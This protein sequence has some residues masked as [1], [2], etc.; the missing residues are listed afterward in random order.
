MI[1]ERDGRLVLTDLLFVSGV[2]IYFG[3]VGSVVQRPWAGAICGVVLALLYSAYA[4]V[5]PRRHGIM[6]GLVTGCVM[7]T[8]VGLL[9]LWVDGVVNSVVSGALFGVLRGGAIGALVGAITRVQPD[10]DDPWHISAFLAVGSV[11][12]GMLLGVGVG[13]MAGMILGG[14]LQRDVWRFLISLPLGM[15]V[16]GYLASYYKRRWYRLLG[17]II[18]FVLALSGLLVGGVWFGL[19]LGLL[20]GAFAPMLLVAAIGAYGGLTSRGVSA[21]LM[22]AAEAPTEMVRQ[23]AVPFLAPAMVVG[24][25]V[26]T[27]VF[28]SGILLALPVSLAVLGL[29]LGALGEIEG[30]SDTR[31]TARTIVEMVILGADEWPIGRLLQRVFKDDHRLQAV[32]GAA[33]GLVSGV[34]ATL[35][36]VWLGQLIMTLQIIN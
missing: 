31:I 17:A 36:G 28:G 10:P 34:I 24:M 14:V 9:S 33:V 18:G 30:K 16:G 7:G 12:V 11:F 23:G 19:I 5:L 32:T 21:M 1:V 4:F 3:I 13:L 2:A 8:A 22:E 25:I 29:L 26:G 27:A 20:S 35:S 15:L 6:S